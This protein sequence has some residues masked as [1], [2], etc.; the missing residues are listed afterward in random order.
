MRASR[1][2]TIYL[3]SSIVIFCFSIFAKLS[4]HYTHEEL[5]LHD[6]FIAFLTVGQLLVISICV[7]TLVIGIAIANC[8]KISQHKAI[9]IVMWLTFLLI[10]YRIGFL[11]APDHM[12]TICKCFGGPGGILGKQSDTVAWIL[13][14]YLII[15]GGITAARLA[16][17][18]TS[19]SRHR[20]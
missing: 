3:V 18:K 16:I 13:L 2:A 1:L 19:L 17:E 4:A 5:Q 6:P 15:F 10:L 12:G 20:T 7:E 14:G 9:G 11:L 8:S